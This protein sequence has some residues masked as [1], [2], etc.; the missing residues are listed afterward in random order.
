MTA[1]H[2]GIEDADLA[3][4]LGIRHDKLG[5]EAAGTAAA[6]ATGALAKS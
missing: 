3:Y 4:K 5:T 2:E 1:T 6:V